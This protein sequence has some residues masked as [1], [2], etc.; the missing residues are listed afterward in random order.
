MLQNVYITLTSLLH[1][2]AILAGYQLGR[3]AELPQAKWPQGGIL[4]F[5]WKA[6]RIPLFVIIGVSVFVSVILPILRS[7]GFTFGGMFGGYGGGGYGGGG[8]GGGYGGG[9]GGG[10]Y[11]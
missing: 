3:Q 7:T 2:L 8:Y 10:M 4:K 6:W 5:G 11:R 1:L 9:W